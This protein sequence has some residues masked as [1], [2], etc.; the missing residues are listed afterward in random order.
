MGV[1]REPKALKLLSSRVSSRG[2]NLISYFPPTYAVPQELILQAINHPHADVR[3]TG[4]R[5]WRG[6]PKPVARA[7]TGLADLSPHPM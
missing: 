2:R 7:V 3:A 4:Y 5:S 6:L 1:A